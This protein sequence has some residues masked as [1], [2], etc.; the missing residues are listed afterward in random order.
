MICAGYCC[1]GSATEMVVTYGHGVQRFTLGQSVR[2]SVY[3]SPSAC[4]C[5]YLSLSRS[6]LCLT[7]CLLDRQFLTLFTSLL[8][9]SL[10]CW[11]IKFYSCCSFLNQIHL[12]ENSFSRVTK[13]NC[14]KC[15]KQSTPSTVRMTYYNCPIIARTIPLKCLLSY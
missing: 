8:F 2:L 7:V 4:V 6:S 3:L 15:A 1:Y 13:W 5:L 12:W 10:L 9:S 14:R 11:A